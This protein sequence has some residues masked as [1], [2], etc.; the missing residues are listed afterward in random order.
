MS[1]TNQFFSPSIITKSLGQRIGHDDCHGEKFGHSPTIAGCLMVGDGYSPIVRHVF[2]RIFNSNNHIVSVGF[3]CKMSCFTA[4]LPVVGEVV[5]GSILVYP[6]GPPK[7]IHSHCLPVL[8]QYKQR[9]FLGCIL[10]V[11]SGLPGPP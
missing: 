4:I 6:Y 2:V 11:D 5:I 1:R 10:Y 3:D 7:L 9:L 8:E